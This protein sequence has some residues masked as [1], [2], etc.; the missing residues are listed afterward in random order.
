MNEMDLDKRVEQFIRLRDKIKEVEDRQK[1]E[2]KPYKEALDK[3]GGLLLEYLDSVNAD[4]VKTKS[5][6]PYKVLDT[7]VT[8]ADKEQYWTWI[9]AQGRFDDLD[10]KPN[11]VATKAY[12]EEQKALSIEDPNVIPSPPPGLNVNQR[13]EIRVVRGKTKKKST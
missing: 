7:S 10:I 11:K 1:E 9:V 4:S 6:T 8:I 5:G 2:L 12:M 3:L 13:Y